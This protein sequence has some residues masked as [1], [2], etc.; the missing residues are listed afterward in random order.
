MRKY[1]NNKANFEF[2]PV[3]HVFSRLFAV[4]QYSTEFEI[5]RK[6]CNFLPTHIVFWP[7]KFV[8]SYCYF[9]AQFVQ[10]RYISNI[11]LKVKL[12]CLLISIILR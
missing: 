4:F 5:S 9:F 12:I 8:R 11:T 6:F 7:I 3:L 2:L 1:A 10:K